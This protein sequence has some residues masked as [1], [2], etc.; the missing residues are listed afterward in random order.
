MTTPEDKIKVTAQW[1]DGG[2]PM[3]DDIEDFRIYVTVLDGKPCYL[4]YD[5]DNGIHAFDGDGLKIPYETRMRFLAVS[6]ESDYTSFKDDEYL[7]TYLDYM[8]DNYYICEL[9]AGHENWF[10]EHAPADSQ[11][12]TYNAKLTFTS[13]DDEGC[14]D[15]IEV[16]E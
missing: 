9:F 13:Y 14:V 10:L 6:I 7:Y 15:D 11:R 2:I 3:P 8:L 16:I 1:I 12:K 5:G 4:D